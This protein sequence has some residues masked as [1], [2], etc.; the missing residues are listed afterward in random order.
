MSEENLIDVAGLGAESFEPAQ[1][2][3]LGANLARAHLSPIA[4]RVQN[5]NLADSIGSTLDYASVNRA[6]IMRRRALE[7][8]DPQAIR[9]QTPAFAEWAAKDEANAV[10]SVNDM[11]WFQSAE[12]ILKSAANE[13]EVGVASSEASRLD[14]YEALARL[15]GTPGLNEVDKARLASLRS[16]IDS[17]G[18]YSG[19]GGIFSDAIISAAQIAPSLLDVVAQT[20][21][22]G[23][24]GAGVGSL[25]G[26]VVPGVGTIAGLISGATT[27]ASAGAIESSA[28]QNFGSMVREFSQ[29]KDENGNLIDQN[30]ADIA[31]A[32]A[33]LP[34]AALDRFSNG[35][36]TALIPDILNIKEQ[37]ARYGLRNA[38]KIPSVQ[39]A[40]MRGARDY[41]TSVGTEA[42]TEGLQQ[43][44]QAT[45]R[46][47]ASPDANKQFDAAS[48]MAEMGSAAYQAGLGTAVIGIPGGAINTRNMVS[49][50]RAGQRDPEVIAQRTASLHEHMQSKTGQESLNTSAPRLRDF[51]KSADGGAQVF[52]DPKPMQ[53][54]FQSLPDDTRKVLLDALPGFQGQLEEAAAADTDIIMRRGDYAA[55]FA[56]QPWSEPLIP[57]VRENQLDVSAAELK[58]LIENKD[59]QNDIDQAA[60]MERL[61]TRLQRRLQDSIQN[62]GV[63]PSIAN[64][65]SRLLERFIGRTDRLRSLA[66]ETGDISAK[67][68]R[69][70]SFRRSASEYVQ[71]ER[72]DELTQHL[73]NIQ[74]RMATEKAPARV[75]RKNFPVLNYIVKTAGGIDPS[76]S[77]GRE[78][79]A[80][81]VTPKTHPWIFKKGGVG[82]IDALDATSL[83]NAFP[84]LALGTS[85]LGK[86]SV[87]D[88]HEIIRQELKNPSVN[89]ED[90]A[91]SAA[92][93]NLMS[94]L[95]EGLGLSLKEI[96]ALTPDN[97]RALLAEYEAGGRSEDSNQF[98]Q[99]ANGKTPYTE[100]T[101]T[102]DGKERPTTNSRGRPIAA[103]KEGLENFWRWFG[104]SITMDKNGRPRVFFHGSRKDFSSFRYD[105]PIEAGRYAGDGIYFSL[106][107]SEASA[108]SKSPQRSADSFEWSGSSVY[109]TYLRINKVFDAYGGDNFAL[110]DGEISELAEISGETTDYIKEEYAVDGHVTQ[111]SSA[112]LNGAIRRNGGDAASWLTK[113]LTQ[114][115]YDGIH[116]GDGEYVVFYPN[117]IKSAIGNN[118]NFSREDNNI[119]HQAANPDAAPI[120]YSQVQ[121][122]VEGLKQGKATAEQWLKTI[123]NTPGVKQEELD[124]MG[125]PEWLAKQ[126]GPVTKAALVEFIN[127]NQITVE[128]VVKGGPI[129]ALPAGDTKF[130]R[131]QLP[132]GENYR[133]LI[134]TLP[135]P[136]PDPQR[137][138]ELE[139]AKEEAKS[140]YQAQERVYNEMSLKI[141]EQMRSNEEEVLAKYGYATFGE[142]VGNSA[143]G[144]EFRRAGVQ[145]PKIKEMK[146]EA[147]RFHT[148]SVIP[149]A[150]RYQTAI[151]MRDRLTEEKDADVFHTDAV[152]RYDD[153]K[154]D[155]NRLAWLRFNERTDAD[156]KR[157]LFIEE[158]QSDWH[159]AGRDKGYALTD[160]EKI[161]LNKPAENQA[162]FDRQN[163]LRQ[164]ANG[165]PDAPFKTTW[166][167]LAFKRALR[168]AVDNG[169]DRVAWTTGEQQADRYDLSKQVDKIQYQPS[170]KTLDAWKDGAIVLA[171]EV[172]VKDLPDVIGKEAADRLL[173]T[174]PISG[175]NKDKH[176]LG[177]IDLKFG[178]EGMRTFYDKMLPSMAN[179]L[180]KKWGGKVGETIIK[181]DNAPEDVVKRF[182]AQDPNH[183]F[184]KKNRTKVHSLDITPAMR[185]AAEAGL[186]LFQETRGSIS[187]D[188]MLERVVISL[189]SGANLS[190]MLHE[191]GHYASLLHRQTAHIARDALAAGKVTDPAARA[192]LEQVIKDWDT[193]KEK[194]GVVGDTLT[195]D[196]EEQIAKWFEQYLR[197]GKS[198]SA[199]LND[200]FA[201]FKS[202]LLQIYKTIKDLGKPINDDVRQVFDRWIA[203]DEE[204]KAAQSV[205]LQIEQIAAQFDMLDATGLSKEQAE[206]RAAVGAKVARLLNKSGNRAS[207]ALLAE[208]LKEE[209]KKQ[210]EEYKADYDKTLEEVTKAADESR[211]YAAQDHIKAGH[212]MDAKLVEQVVGKDIAKRL[213]N[214]MRGGKSSPDLIAM[215]FGYIDGAEMIREIVS[216]VPKKVFIAQETERLMQARHGN[217]LEDGRAADRAKIL[218][219]NDEVG[220]AIE[221]LV[222]T[223]GEK[224][225][226]RRLVK[227]AARQRMLNT[228]YADIT[229]GK[230]SAARDKALRA[231]YAAGTKAKGGDAAQHLWKAMLNHELL[232]AANEMRAEYAKRLASWKKLTNRPTAKGDEKLAKAYDLDLLDVARALL[233]RVGLGT[234][235]QG[236]DVAAKL[237]E[238]GGDDLDLLVAA[239]HQVGKQ[240]KSYKDMTGREF[241][242]FAEAI[243]NIRKVSRDRRT[244]TL[245][246][247]KVAIKDFQSDMRNEFLA[248]MK[249]DGTPMNSRAA[250]QDK[251]LR[252]KGWLMHTNGFLMRMEHWV[253]SIE[254]DNIT[255]PLH[256][257]FRSIKTACNNYSDALTFVTKDMV[258]IL[259]PLDG[260][261]DRNSIDA[262]EL[263][264]GQKIMG[265]QQLFGLLLHIGNDSN[266]EKL[267]GGFAP[268]G[269]TA[270]GVWKFVQRMVNEG[271]LTRQDIDAVQKVW[272]LLNTLKPKAQQAH[273][274]IY[275]FRFDEVTS[276]PFTLRIG[277]EDV[278]FSGGYFPAIA[279]PRLV[280]DAAQR[281]KIESVMESN[282]VAMWPSTSKGWSK[283][284]VE[285]YQA[286]LQLDAALAVSHVA[287]VLKFIHLESAVRQATRVFKGKDLQT[288]IGAVNPFIV[289]ETVLPWLQRVAR[290]GMDTKADAPDGITRQLNNLRRY[291]GISAMALNVV[292]TVQQVFDMGSVVHELGAAN[293]SRATSQYLSSPSASVKWVTKLSGEMRNRLI[294]YQE[295]MP[296]AV[297]QILNNDGN[298][299]RV[300]DAAIHHG[301]VLQRTAQLQIDMVTFIAAY[302][303][304]I[305]E[306]KNDADSLY[307]A[308]RAVRLTQSSTRPEDVSK[309]ESSA[310]PWTRLFI[311]FYGWF[312]NKYNQQVYGVAKLL[313]ENGM[314]GASPKIAYL[315][316][317]TTVIPFVL[318]QAVYDGF[319]GGL[320]DDDDDDGVVDDWLFW[321]MRSMF[322]GLA[323]EIPIAGQVANTM[324]NQW[325]D[326]PYNDQ[327]TGSPALN[328]ISRAARAPRSAYRLMTDDNKDQSAA[329]RDMLSL[330]T[331]TTGVPTGQIGKTGGYLLDIGEGDTKP[332]GAGDVAAGLLAGTPHK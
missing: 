287:K 49:G 207:E 117:Q 14:A 157:V 196:Q 67:L 260:T 91:R 170:T 185:E 82:E 183:P 30:T 47:F 98:D 174:D 33:T 25:A 12:H 310:G 278:E 1:P 4:N 134:F 245:E 305:A 325:D 217:M 304:A 168:W 18:R 144:N 214:G 61:E 193:L 108:Y 189:S 195:V 203:S 68:E 135:L 141:V 277:G 11:G 89:K 282:S 158:I 272:D 29:L 73:T 106:N 239:T 102:V 24:V 247:Q 163:E 148:D 34:V 113:L 314:K 213:P 179:K 120:F 218:V 206:A 53:E 23:A 235:I 99:A 237:I 172:E 231:A 284:R 199:E 321:F 85:E 270:D 166:P 263:G 2:D 3:P 5:V 253:R 160:A 69:A 303:K 177:G 255:G 271:K 225:Q 293:V 226:T 216:N 112:R 150:R 92:E 78:L 265:R 132:G 197:E 22:G 56:S 181:G 259:K 241:R 257:I 297:R 77:F 114:H 161:E 93:D 140:A 296:S 224:K 280:P 38:V 127:A 246:G 209:S 221:L 322:S 169:F 87:N 137:L 175:R 45:A 273:Y 227:A 164:R 201:T 301:Y 123:Q 103:T 326:K 300:R 84:K 262:P 176:E 62:A 57:H 32:I 249:A 243:D 229:P 256:R 107:P 63:T 210:T 254:G 97:L 110:S 268:E 79:A 269:W 222:K 286:P 16:G 153:G 21:K 324:V 328:L 154:S 251:W 125:L 64:T 131:W 43:G 194:L 309:A 275:G 95:D 238:H 212:Q 96:E 276:R 44:I 109:P 105:V 188:T 332:Q 28:M 119:L 264:A 329:F 182:E 71:P 327:F 252:A 184:V 46:Y 248:L 9:A 323:A 142:G 211:V 198:P 331:I 289:T 122:V 228:R 320:P 171:K 42:V 133:E 39:S 298:L 129:D 200:I 88:L 165:V 37:L 294:V 266:F 180:T 52:I 20:A 295:E 330:L 70:L 313:R 48:I 8:I 186:A 104:E 19:T 147:E 315:M 291:A 40:L 316:L 230:Y 318:G 292:N 232:M 27:G 244:L 60:S 306:G 7:A 136:K 242:E 285:S 145:N 138:A 223:A 202:W 149:L 50:V 76:G 26:S 146:K 17:A 15:T 55:L 118:G 281:V 236:Y 94:L 128:E 13:F 126:D 116:N 215:Q 54:L 58:A 220:E 208:V 167:E 80:Q 6:D 250:E 288:A 121:R 178:G 191:F 173:K 75:S 139:Q 311:M 151:A 187:F 190:T 274:Q 86:Y 302:N 111:S 65:Q 319:T 240:V 81:D 10:M 283:T 156:G 155:D 31:A 258:S 204:I 219:A 41:V 290:Q 66:G 143:F 308:E 36:M 101:I 83:K 261:F 279:N 130:G 162:Q 35:K 192:E 233:G 90:T 205:N 124:W 152:H 267:V 115:G 234:G 159:Q 51:M 59:V 299:V 72:V 307:Y 100:P 317:M 312:N 74:A